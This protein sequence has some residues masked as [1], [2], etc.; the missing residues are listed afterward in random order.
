MKSK[1]GKGGQTSTLGVTIQSVRQSK[2]M[3]QQELGDRVGLPKSSIS[4]IER[5]LTHISFEDA[6]LLLDAMGEKLD[7]RLLGGQA[8]LSEKIERS[9]FVTVCTIWYAQDKRMTYSDAYR[10]L[11]LYKGIQFL[12]DNCKYEQTLSRATILEDLEK[13]CQR[14]GAKLQ[15]AV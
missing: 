15:E 13:V 4:K 5:G 7:V 6:A 9:R 3:T 11:L 8:A 1:F 14:Q 12:E 2:G 10:Y